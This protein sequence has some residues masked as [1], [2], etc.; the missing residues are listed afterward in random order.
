MNMLRLPLVM[1]VKNCSS[2]EF[3]LI[4]RAFFCF[5]K[6]FR[7]KYPKNVQIPNIVTKFKKE[8]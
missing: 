5:M 8:S 1:H 2:K 4:G 6:H 3:D 7:V